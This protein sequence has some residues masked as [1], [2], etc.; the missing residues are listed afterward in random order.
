MVDQAGCTWVEIPG[1]NPPVHIQIQTG[2]PQA[3][4]RAWVADINAY[5]EHVRDADTACWT[6]TNSVDTSNHL[7]ATA[8]DVD[9]ELHPFRVANA[10]FNS[11]QIATIRE[12][13]DFYEGT[14]FWGNDWSNPKDSMHFQ[15][16]S[17]ANGGD[18]DTYNNP[19]TGDFI[20]RKIRADGFST[21]RRANNPAPPPPPIT[22]PAQLSR[23][24]GYA[25]RIL[26]EGRKRGVTPKG[27]Q[28]AFA[29]G[30][31][32]SNITVYANQ[33]LPKSLAL[34]HDAV[35]NDGYSVGI[36]QQQVR[37][38]RRPAWVW[39]PQPACST[40]G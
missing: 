36:F 14:V 28:I 8:V 3:I 20:A 39:S 16:A 27:I 24:E 12:M 4:L 17:R 11:G 22:P 21:F 15:L 30:I 1:T 29:T 23:A 31:V 25:L 26:N 38:T 32:E 7:S 18:I 40:T 2:Q 19:H 34:P 37:D 13:L 9:W 35:G 6:G 33:K 10:G 5:V